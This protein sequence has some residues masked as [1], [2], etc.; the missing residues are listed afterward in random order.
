MKSALF[1]VLFLLSGAF[2]SCEKE[3]VPAPNSPGASLEIE[4]RVSG[5]TGH[6]YVDYTVAENG[7]MTTKSEEFNRTENSIHFE[8]GVGHL[9]SV[10]ARN[11]SPSAKEVRADIYVNGVLF[12]SGSANAPGA[13]AVAEGNY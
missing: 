2:V 4:Y 13:I 8:I 9:L 10:K 12:K 11:A 5:E 6:F 1:S 7:Q 3:E